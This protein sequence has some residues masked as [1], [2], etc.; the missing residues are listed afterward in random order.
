[1]EVA[2]YSETEIEAYHSRMDRA[3]IESTVI[4]VAKAEGRAAGVTQMNRAMRAS[5]MATEQIS[6]VTPLPIAE[7]QRSLGDGVLVEA[8][9]SGPH[10]NLGGQT[11]PEKWN[12]LSKPT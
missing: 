1:V 5:G 2:A 8:L 7:V 4:T 6:Q 11:V 12:G 3:R 9:A 10:Q